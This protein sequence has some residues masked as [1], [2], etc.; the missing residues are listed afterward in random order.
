MT[1]RTNFSTS[2]K[3]GQ[4]W[5]NSSAR[6]C[7]KPLKVIWVRAEAARTPETTSGYPDYLHGFWRCFTVSDYELMQLDQEQ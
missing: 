7:K 1:A 2:G 5:A 6:I 3:S 4:T